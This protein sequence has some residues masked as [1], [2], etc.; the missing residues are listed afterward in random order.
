MLQRVSYDLF[1]D[2][3]L[4]RWHHSFGHIQTKF[5]PNS[6]Q[7]QTPW[8]SMDPAPPPPL[9]RVATPSWPGFKFK[10]KWFAIRAPDIL[11]MLSY[12]FNTVTLVWEESIAWANGI[13]NM[14]IWKRKSIWCISSYPKGWPRDI[15]PP[16]TFTTS[17]LMPRIWQLAEKYWSSQFSI[18]LLALLMEYQIS[19]I[20]TTANASLISQSAMS[21]GVT[22]CLGDILCQQ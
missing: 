9:Q 13:I 6:N 16:W 5:K 7:V 22:P 21:E 15:A 4:R 17:V 2:S 18:Q 3:L 12:F 10:A 20:T 8:I 11:K 14:E 19:P 1:L